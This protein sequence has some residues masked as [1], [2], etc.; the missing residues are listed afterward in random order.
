MLLF[1]RAVLLINCA[2]FTVTVAK[3]CSALVL[4]KKSFKDLHVLP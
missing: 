3:N 2:L 1:G 4:L